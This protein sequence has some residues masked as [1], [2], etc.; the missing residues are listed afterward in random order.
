MHN[1]I[2]SRAALAKPG[3]SGPTTSSVLSEADSAPEQEK[4]MG[5]VENICAHR[6]QLRTDI[7]RPT[8][9]G[10]LCPSRSRNR[11]HSHAT[12]FHS[13]RGRAVSRFMPRPVSQRRRHRPREERPA[14]EAVKEAKMQYARLS[15][16]EGTRFSSTVSL[17]SLLKRSTR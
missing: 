6:T 5:H 1:T 17:Y 8:R 2:G 16:L 4:Q 15:L 14:L 10:C 12:K 7:L 13:D 11:L 9:L 3:D